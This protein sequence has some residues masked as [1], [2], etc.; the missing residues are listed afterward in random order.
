[1]RGARAKALRKQA[2]RMWNA[3]TKREKLDAFRTGFYGRTYI[4]GGPRRIY[5]NLKT[6]WTAGKMA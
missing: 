2:L 5:R 4:I 3:L 1:M 6:L